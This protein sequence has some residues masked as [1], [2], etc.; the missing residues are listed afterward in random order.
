MIEY[1]ANPPSIMREEF[2]DDHRRNSWVAMV[3]FATGRILFDKAGDLQRLRT[4]A[5]EWI[6]K[7]FD[8][9]RDPATVENM[10]YSLWDTLDNVRDAYETRSP[11][12]ALVHH[13]GL[14]AVFRIYSRYVAWHLPETHQ[15]YGLLSNPRYRARYGIPGF[16]D[17]TFVTLF[18]EAAEMRIPTKRA[19]VPGIESHRLSPRTPAVRE[20]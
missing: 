16:P 15:I 20:C 1:F 3:P 10:K 14:A 13:N 11:D 4:E 8:P 6:A 19:G 12:Y 17:G 7:P 18:R 2:R 5:Q 9:L